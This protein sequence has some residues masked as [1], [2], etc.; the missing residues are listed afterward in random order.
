MSFS[1]FCHV[2]LHGSLDSVKLLP[3]LFL[4]YLAMEL[5]EHKAG[6]GVK[7]V[8]VKAGRAGPLLGA[9]L[10]LVPQC[11]FSAVAAG[12]FAARIVTPG[13]VLAVFLATSDEMIPVMLGA[14]IPFWRVLVI[15]AIK[16]V[17]A[18]CVGFLV[19]L[20]MRDRHHTLHVHDFCDEEH[21]HCENGIWRSAIHHTLHVFGFVLLINLL[22]GLLL[23][24]VGEEALSA[25]MRGIPLL[26]ELLAAAVGLI[27]N[28]AASV[29]IATLYAKGAIGAGAM[30]AGLLSGA[31]AGLLVLFRTNRPRRQN[32]F[33]ALAL[34]LVGVLFGCILEYTGMDTL[35]G[36]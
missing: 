18:T 5:L 33:F 10:G 8:I 7:K 36:L 1:E 6:D 19:D 26:G 25:C 16:L 15:L 21:C 23:E 34:L 11:G 27:P 12:L 31:G 32:L 14:G 4:T 28:C 29:A 35:F 13:T 22:L 24:L 9:L 2:L 30:L 20:M 3:F 17:I